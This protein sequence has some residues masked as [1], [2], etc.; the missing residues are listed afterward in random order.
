MSFFYLCTL[1]ITPYV[2]LYHYDL[3]QVLHD[4][5]NGWLSPRIV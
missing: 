4:Q 2:A 5:Y 3:P 1:E